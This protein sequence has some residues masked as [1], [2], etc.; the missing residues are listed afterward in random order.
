MA[1]HETLPACGLYRTTVAHPT[2]GEQVP[3][4]RLVHFHNH[5]NSDKPIVLMPKSNTHNV[6]EFHDRGFLVESDEWCHTL[7]PLPAEGMYMT[8][9]PLQL[10]DN[11]VAEGQLI[12]LGYNGFA[13]P[14][15]FFPSK[16]ASANALM[17]PDKGMKVERTLLAHL[18][19]VVLAGPRKVA[20]NVN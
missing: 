18:R 11:A 16:A 2:K 12:Q 5:S 10:G 1:E 6:W 14:I 3:E 4:G 15:L 20:A 9:A 17:I 19:P 13:D 8:T 7:E